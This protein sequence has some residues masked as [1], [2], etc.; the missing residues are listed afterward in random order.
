LPQMTGRS[1]IG[2]LKGKREANRDHVFL[3]RE[4]HANVRRGDF[5]YPVRA[6]RTKEFLYVRNLRPD[7]WP[8]G[9]P[10]YYYAVGPYGDVDNSPTKDLLLNRRDDKLI[11]R[12]FHWAFAKRPAEELFDLTRDPAQL[13]NVA[14]QPRYAAHMRR[15]RNELDQWM[16]KTGDPRATSDD[17]RWDRFRYFGG[18]NPMPVRQ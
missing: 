5:S 13:T 9:D 4:R 8:G 6:V 11:S 7:R 1:L 14:D 12:Y 15:L 2:L 3:E 17:D 10:E 16:V 18:K